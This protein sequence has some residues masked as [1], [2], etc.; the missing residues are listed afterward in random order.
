MSSV[1]DIFSQP[2]HQRPL[3]Q[4]PLVCIW[5]KR[6]PFDVP[7][8]EKNTSV[9]S[10]TQQC[11]ARDRDWAHHV[12]FSHKKTLPTMWSA[13][14]GEELVSEILRTR[15]AVVWK[16]CKKEGLQ[17]DWE[18]EDAIWEVKTRNWNTSGTAG[19]KVLGVI[20]KY[21]AVPR[22]YGKRLNIVCVGYQEVDKTGESIFANPNIEQQLLLAYAAETLNIHFVKCTDLLKSIQ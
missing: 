18:T 17:P 19:E 22:L 15:G 2:V 3:L 8:S 10:R 14:F 5:L 1:L 21:A 20:Y 7:P 11:Q 4:R 12:Y 6:N 13:A 9:K 16:P